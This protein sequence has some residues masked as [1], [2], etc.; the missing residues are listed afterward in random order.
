MSLPMKIG[1]FVFPSSDPACC[2]LRGNG[3]GRPPM[4]K[5]SSRKP[6]LNF[7]VAAVESTME[8][9][10]AERHGLGKPRRGWRAGRRRPIN[11]LLLLHNRCV[12]SPLISFGAIAGRRDAARP[13]LFPMR[14][15]QSSRNLNWA[16]NREQRTRRASRELA[17]RTTRG[18]GHENLERTH[19]RRDRDRARH[20]PQ[21]RRFALPLRAQRAEEKFSNAMNDFYSGI[22]AGAKKLRP[23]R[24]R[25]KGG[26]A[27][28]MRVGGGG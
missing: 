11:R 27:N 17:A 9:A 24:R 10:G 19:F 6:S 3:S 26:G 13:K 22:E 21:H 8:P 18:A 28:Q 4:P 2:F 12:R 16:T 25:R 5:T 1:K 14:N 23:A 20:F 15:N 7:G